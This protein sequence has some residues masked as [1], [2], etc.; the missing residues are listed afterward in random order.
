MR[1]GVGDQIFTQLERTNDCALYKRS[2]PDGKVVGFEVIEIKTVKA[3][4]V[5]AKGSKPTES[6][7]E[8]Y[9]GGQS[10]GKSAWFTPIETRAWTRFDKMVLGA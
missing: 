8:S 10:F 4:T 2:K 1:M 7:Y 6:D 3:G 5:F 9:P